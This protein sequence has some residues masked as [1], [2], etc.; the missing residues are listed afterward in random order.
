M[1]GKMAQAK[2]DSGLIAYLQF[3]VQ[4]M[5]A[6][7]HFFTC[8][9]VVGRRTFHSCSHVNTMQFQSIINVKGAR[10]ICESSVV[11]CLHEE[12]SAPISC[13]HSS[14]S[15]AAMRRRS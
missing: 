1:I 3:L 14:G 9:L 5:R 8:G 10:L 6:V 13:E 15:I 2:D 11:K 7:G 4:E 12:I